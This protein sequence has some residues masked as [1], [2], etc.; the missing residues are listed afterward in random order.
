MVSLLLWSSRSLANASDALPNNTL[1]TFAALPSSQA[2]TSTGHIFAM[3]DA[4]TSSL[5]NAY[6]SIASLLC[7]L[8]A[9]SVISEPHLAFPHKCGG[10]RQ[11]TVASI[12]DQHLLFC[13]SISF[14]LPLTQHRAALSYTPVTSIPRHRFFFLADLSSRNLPLTRA[15]NE[16]QVRD[17][18]Q[19]SW[20]HHSLS[21]F[22]RLQALPTMDAKIRCRSQ[23]S[24]DQLHED[25]HLR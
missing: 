13:G 14:S 11:T 8:L 17:R 21:S 19:A 25:S 5:V 3:L 18:S 6:C 20:I 12:P 1:C 2:P 23:A 9:G 4:I 24:N 10:A 7:F 15:C 16:C 22:S